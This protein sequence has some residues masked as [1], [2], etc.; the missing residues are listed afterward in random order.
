MYLVT[1]LAGSAALS[2]SRPRG[3]EAS[4]LWMMMAVGATASPS[5]QR[6]STAQFRISR[7]DASFHCIFV[8]GSRRELSDILGHWERY[9]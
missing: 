6:G 9:T 2:N 3:A 8:I 7:E 4:S 1:Q 5:K